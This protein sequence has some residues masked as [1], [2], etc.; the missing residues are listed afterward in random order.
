[1]T[2]TTPL[3]QIL[4]NN[5]F[6]RHLA[7]AEKGVAVEALAILDKEISYLACNIAKFDLQT[8]SGMRRT[9]SSAL[10]DT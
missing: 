4:G 5:C 6:F 3:G 1:L 9:K 2:W 7:R 10:L 8:K